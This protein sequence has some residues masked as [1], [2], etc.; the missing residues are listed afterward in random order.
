MPLVQRSLVLVA[1][2][3]A[4]VSGDP[5]GSESDHDED[6]GMCWRNR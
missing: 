3:L 2:L 4:C 1:L 6:V 5:Q